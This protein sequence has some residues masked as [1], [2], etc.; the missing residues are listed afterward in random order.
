MERREDDASLK[1][2]LHLVL[3]SLCLAATL[4]SFQGVELAAQGALPAFPGAQGYGALATGGRAGEV[5]H[6]TNL[7]DS[8]PGSF[9]DAVSRGPRIVVFD[10]GGYIELSSPI[11]VRSNITI[12]GQTAPGDGIATRNYEVSFSGSNNVIIRHI[13]FRQGLTPGQD[14]KSAVNIA[15]G[16]NMIFDHVSIEWGRWDTVDMTGSSNITIQYSIIGEGIAPQNFGCLCQSDSITLSHDVWINNQSRNPK[17]KGLPVQYVSNVVYNWGVTG[18]VGGHS[19]AD[20]YLDVI[21]NYFIA[22]PSSNANFVG[23]FTSTDQVYHSGNFVDFDMDGQ[24]NGREVVDADF[25]GASLIQTP[26]ASPPVPVT[27]DSA[28]DAYAIAVAGAGASL[29][30]DAVDARLVVYLTSLGG[31]GQIIDDPADVGGFG[32]LMGG[33]PPA[34]CAGDGLP[35]DWKIRYGLDPC[36]YSA[37]DDFDGTGY[38]NIEKFINSLID[39]LYP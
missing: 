21:N 5:Y 38:T 32:V 2:V 10:V 17:A 19:A 9:R 26:S 8:G 35:D 22:G 12:A 4:I 6:V 27:P 37:N 11:S 7:D 36:T 25:A 30:R 13:R 34:S 14:R 39:G 33:D 20:H 16:T 23:D 1:P 15:T 28:G 18:L 3:K 24:L 31:Q 29:N